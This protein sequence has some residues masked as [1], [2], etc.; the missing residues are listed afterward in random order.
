[1][2][3]MIKYFGERLIWKLAY[4]I[5]DVVVVQGSELQVTSYK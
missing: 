4:G 5:L 2:E 3:I 1:M